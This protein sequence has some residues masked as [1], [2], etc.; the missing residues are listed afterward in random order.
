MYERSP[1]CS[2]LTESR[3]MKLDNRELPDSE[4]ANESLMFILGVTVGAAVPL[5]IMAAA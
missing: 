2:A 4:G 5:L 1:Q 3:G